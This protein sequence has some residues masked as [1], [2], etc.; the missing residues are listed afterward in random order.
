MQKPNIGNNNP[1]NFLP[2]LFKFQ[3]EGFI[4]EQTSN[5][6]RNINNGM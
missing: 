5:P 3:Q 4:T 6:E 1:R 2:S